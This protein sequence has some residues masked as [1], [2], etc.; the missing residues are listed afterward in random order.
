MK[1]V[2]IFVLF[3]TICLGLGAQSL[4][5]IVRSTDPRSAAMG[6]VGTENLAAGDA[7]SGKKIDAGASFGTA[8][9]GD[10][11]TALIGLGGYGNIGNLSVGLYGRYNMQPEYET[12][13]DVSR[14]LGFFRPC[15][16]S[17]GVS[18][19]YVVADKFAIGIRGSYISSKLTSGAA[20][21]GFGADISAAFS[22]GGLTVEAAA[23]NLGPKIK[24]GSYE[25]ALPSLAALGVSYKIGAFKAKAE[26]DYLFAG[27]FMAGAGAE[28]TFAKVFSLRAGFH[29]GKDD[30]P[31]PMYASIG[32]GVQIAGLRIDVTYMPPLGQM[33]TGQA[34][35]G[36]GFSR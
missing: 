29:Y 26:A 34:C 3:L 31:V 8:L 14:S 4:P 22:T 1:K 25:Y 17:V 13:N 28:Y 6:S 20:A 35:A 27:S 21:S 23:R 30:S 7:L 11:K 18:V 2:S 36:I 15:E 16:M 9:P 19:A 24:Y 12:F 32:L 5:F 10:F 33:T